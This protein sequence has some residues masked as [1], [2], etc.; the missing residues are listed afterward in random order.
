MHYLRNN[1][2]NSKNDNVDFLKI[3]T[4]KLIIN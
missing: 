4:A 1:E 3:N 2:A